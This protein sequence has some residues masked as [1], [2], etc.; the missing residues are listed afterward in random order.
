M[1]TQTS[2]PAPKKTAAKR[3]A[4]KPKTK[5]APA[6]KRAPAPADE[7]SAR[8]IRNLE[9]AAEFFNTR[10]EELQRGGQMLTGMERDQ[11][12]SACVVGLRHA[13]D[14]LKTLKE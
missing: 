12:M 2:K 7:A 1:S 11:R 10:I 5:P 4:A 6:P 14:A 9:T 13:I 8:H 3:P